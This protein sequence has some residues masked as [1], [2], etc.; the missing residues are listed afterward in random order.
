MKSPRK[1]G[2]GQLLLLAAAL[3][4]ALA[5]P[6]HAEAPTGALSEYAL[7]STPVELRLAYAAEPTDTDTLL[8]STSG[9]LNLS[10]SCNVSSGELTP[11]PET[12][13]LYPCT[14]GSGSVTVRLDGDGDALV[15]TTRIVEPRYSYTVNVTSE[16]EDDVSAA[17]VLWR[18][19]SAPL[20]DDGLLS[21][22][23]S[24][25]NVVVT[26]EGATSLRYAIPSAGLTAA[27]V[28]ACP[29]RGSCR[30]AGRPFSDPPAV[31][32]SL[33]FAA[34]TPFGLVR[35]D[36]FNTAQ[37]A[38]TL[39]WE[40]LAETGWLPLPRVQDGTAGLNQD[41]FIA[42][43]ELLEPMVRRGL[44]VLGGRYYQ[45]RATVA[46]T[47]GIGY[48]TIASAEVD[49]GYW[50][51]TLAS[52]LPA[53]G[54]TVL[55][56]YILPPSEL[57]AGRSVGPAASL[58]SS[59]PAGIETAV[60]P[61]RPW[62]RPDL[63][64]ALA[65]AGAPPVGEQVVEAIGRPIREDGGLPFI[66]FAVEQATTAA[67]VPPLVLWIIIGMAIAFAVLVGVQR[68]ASNILLSV[69]AGGLVLGLITT[70][71]IGI[72]SVWGLMVYALIGGAVVLIGRRLAL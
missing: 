12:V 10:P 24:T 44:D 52:T 22:S 72:S 39:E 16:R 2:P 20:Y 50:Q 3:G 27:E 38:P 58:L 69:I 34:R 63:T 62:Q 67:N 33:Y 41:G 54:A 70:P 30:S 1:V 57:V 46:S 55:R 65:D 37:R 23:D 26:D 5:S 43:D 53:G 7:L 59:P 35:A 11:P 60:S 29:S 48:S 42:W 17:H 45:V 32:D 9:A 4:L 61:W 19:F 49:G 36:I 66:G 71:S 15:K 14:V 8:V 51:A 28:L 25:A 56:V 40:Y 18:A 6:V 21:S 31:G 68:V 13:R 64:P 47:G